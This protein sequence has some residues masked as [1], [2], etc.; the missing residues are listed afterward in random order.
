MALGRKGAFA[1]L[2]I[3]IIFAFVIVVVSGIF[4]YIGEITTAKLHE[5]M[6]GMSI[7]PHLNNSELINNTMGKVNSAFGSLYWISIFIIIGMILSIFIGSYLVTTKPIFF[8]PYIFIIIIAVVISVGISNAYEQI[9]LN[10]ILA[11][12]FDDFVGANFIMSKLPIWTAIIGFIG[13]IIMFSRL[14][15]KEETM[16]YG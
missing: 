16:Y 1:D 5:K 14:G 6:D 7:S 13:A 3:F 15:S 4:I 11:S 9:A 12:T 8:I 10:P 2:F